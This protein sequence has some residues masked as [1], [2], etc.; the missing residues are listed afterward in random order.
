[1]SIEWG[2]PIEVNGERPD[3]LAGDDQVWF[4]NSANYNEKYRRVDQLSFKIVTHVHL[5]ADHW[6][7]TVA[8][9]N[10][11]HPEEVP[12][13]P[14]GG[15]DSAPEE[16]FGHYTQAQE[17]GGG[18]IMLRNGEV[19]E[20]LY[21]WRWDH[22]TQVDECDIIGYRKKA[23]QQVEA[24][25]EYVSIKRRTAEEWSDFIMAYDG[26]A[27]ARY[28]RELLTQLGLIIKHEPTEA[29]RIAHQTGVALD[30]VEAV[31]KARGA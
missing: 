8:R 21:G 26:S 1:M 27:M 5:P 9:W 2:D 18:D 22:G 28:E 11:A 10:A 23:G 15:G 25:D 16:S 24:G 31:L 13:T 6:Y 12:F 17:G 29:E 7:Y 4:F 14:W 3:W 19:H 20:G 30:V